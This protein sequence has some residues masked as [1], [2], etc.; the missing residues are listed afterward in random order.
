[1][2]AKRV[3]CRLEA[4]LAPH[5]AADNFIKV[6]Q[7]APVRIAAVSQDLIAGTAWAK[8]AA[9]SSVIGW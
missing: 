2:S 6:V 3:E 8:P 5:N 9:P 1:L 7:C 4:I